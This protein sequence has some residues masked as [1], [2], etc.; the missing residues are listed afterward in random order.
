MPISFALL[1]CG[2]RCSSRYAP[3]IQEKKSPFSNLPNLSSPPISA[4]IGDRGARTLFSTACS[5]TVPSPP[6]APPPATP[7]RDRG[8]DRRRLGVSCLSSA[9]ADLV[10]A[11]LPGGLCVREARLC[12]RPPPPGAPTQYGPA[13]SASSSTGKSSSPLRRFLGW[14]SGPPCRPPRQRVN[15]G[16]GERVSGACFLAK[17][18]TDCNVS[19]NA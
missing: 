5:T 17:L 14:G 16:R 6:H 8:T 2:H 10:A 1:Q 11:C 7:P 19:T 3:R 13:T 9:P 15:R 4:Q 12:R 18:D